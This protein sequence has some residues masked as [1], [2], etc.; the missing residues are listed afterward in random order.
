MHSKLYMACSSNREERQTRNLKKCDE[1]CANE[2]SWGHCYEILQLVRKG[3]S[4]AV[5]TRVILNGWMNS[6]QTGEF[7]FKVNFQ[8]TVFVKIKQ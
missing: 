1:C 3:F 7:R 4:K 2:S 6:C 8:Q 5:T